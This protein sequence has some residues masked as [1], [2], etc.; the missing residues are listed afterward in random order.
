MSTIYVMKM[1]ISQ[2]DMAIIDDIIVQK[3]LRIMN[4]N[5]YLQTLKRL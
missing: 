1:E 2:I 4:V 5:S 3:T